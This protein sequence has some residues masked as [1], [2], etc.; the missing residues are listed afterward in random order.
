MAEKIFTQ[1]ELNRIISSRLNR[2][3]GRLAKEFEKRM[4]RCMA[5]VH[6]TLYEEMCSMKRELDAEARDMLLSDL[7]KEWEESLQVSIGHGDI[8]GGE[9]E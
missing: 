1:D 8:G 4:K 2:E 5:S 7:P 3:R 9:R 6:L